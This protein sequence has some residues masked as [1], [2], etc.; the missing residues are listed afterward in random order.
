[1]RVYCDACPLL[2]THPHLVSPSGIDNS[3]ISS[4][5]KTSPNLTH[6]R[7]AEIG[8][9]DDTSLALLHPL[10]HLEYLDLSHG[11]LDGKSFTDEGVIA[12]LENVG[13]NLTTLILDDNT[14]LTDRT[15]IEGVKVNCPN[16]TELSLKNLDDILPTGVAELF[17]EDWV[18]QKGMVRLNLHRC[19]QL[20]DQALEA[21]INHS[22]KSLT[23][24][25]LNSVDA[26]TEKGLKCLANHCP[27]LVELDVSFVREVWW[28]KH[29]MDSV[30][31]IT[32]K[33]F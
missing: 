21:V 25:D 22:G 11:G 14:A 31:Q 29:M 19:T 5:V 23:K 12:L 26:I 32:G 9:L 6:L 1:M 16:L 20:D 33:S 30:F 17:N 8:C 7:L 28:R 4:L 3:V 15:L 10:K 18:N 27:N 24:L 13:T 2:L